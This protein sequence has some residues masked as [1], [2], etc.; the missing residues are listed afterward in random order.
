MDVQRV[1][2]TPRVTKPYTEA[3]W[4]AILAAGAEVDRALEGRA[5]A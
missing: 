5:C 2:E 1:L 3:Q 4:Q